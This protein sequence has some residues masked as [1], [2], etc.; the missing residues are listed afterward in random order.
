VDASELRI[1]ASHGLE[2]VVAVVGMQAAGFFRMG[3]NVDRNDVIDVGD[4]QLGHSG[5]HRS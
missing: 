2:I 5:I 4:F 1:E 3:V